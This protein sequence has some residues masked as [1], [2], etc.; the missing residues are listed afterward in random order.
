MSSVT[1]HHVIKHHITTDDLLGQLGIKSFNHYYHTRLL[2]WAGHVARMKMDRLPRK[3]M[4]G[5]V[6]NKR[7]TGGPAM[8]WGR[9]LNKALHSKQIA[10]KFATWSALAQNPEQWRAAILPNKAPRARPGVQAIAPQAAQDPEPWRAPADAAVRAAFRTAHLAKRA[11]T[12]ATAAAALA[13]A[14]AAVSAAASAA[15]SAAR[16]VAAA[17]GS[18]R[19]SRS[20]R[21]N[22]SCDYIY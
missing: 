8:T 16:Q 6:Y 15:A 5:F 21:S 2:R 13:A 7:L 9:T 14:S 22:R 12:A 4:T 19:S 3:L 17:V 18:R 11:A 10:T 1:M 20:R